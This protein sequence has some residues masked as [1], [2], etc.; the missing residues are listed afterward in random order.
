MEICTRA[1]DHPDSA[2]LIAEL[3]QVFV[4]R[5]GEQDA[6]PVD[7]A[8]FAAPLGHF[9][10]GYLDGV[11][12]A[13]GG[14]RAHDVADGS[15]RV[16][17]AEIKRM[18]TADSLR[19]KGLARV[20]LAGLETAARVAGRRRMVLETGLRQPEAIGLYESSGYRRIDNF[21]VYRHHPESLCYAK[22][23]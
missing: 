11:P 15:I 8:Q 18:Y 21:G 2:K 6:T 16:G 12:V 3:Q 22:D 19:G 14:W 13:C 10:V 20:V 23:L 5:Y 9:V 7:P 17:D 1:Y 4:V